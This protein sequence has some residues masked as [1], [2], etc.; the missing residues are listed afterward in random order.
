MIITNPLIGDLHGSVGGLTFFK[1]PQYQLCRMKTKPHVPNSPNI[2]LE[3]RIMSDASSLWDVLDFY[4]KSL[5]D[6]FASTWFH[7]HNIHPKP[8][9]K[10]FHA[11]ISLYKMWYESFL[12]QCSFEY[13]FDAGPVV[14]PLGASF[15]AFSSVPPT[16]DF[17]VM[18]EYTDHTAVPINCSQIGLYSDNSV[19]FQVN[20]PHNVPPPLFT[21]NWITPF[22][23]RYW[24]NVWCSEPLPYQNAPAKDFLRYNLGTPG[25]VDNLPGT[26]ENSS[27]CTFKMYSDLVIQKNNTFPQ[28][29]NWV[30]LGID[31]ICES[32]A[33][34][35]LNLYCVQIIDPP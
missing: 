16:S 7:P 18:L 34:S 19:V 12:K 6:V 14:P 30:W 31:A 24:F 29:G 21:N 3:Q 26:L 9:Y 27:F 4:T 20:Y 1:T 10:G 15:P 32:G 8:P 11:Y 13:H 28:K 5:W 25:F 2:L 22:N 35:G 33:F 23:Q 17:Y